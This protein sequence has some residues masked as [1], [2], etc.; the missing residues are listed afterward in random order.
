MLEGRRYC[1]ELVGSG[2]VWVAASFAAL[3]ALNVL[4]YLYGPGQALA[5]IG[6][7]RYGPLV[8]FAVFDSWGTVEGLLGTVALFVPLL[9]VAEGSE[10]RAMSAFFVA[11][12]LGAGFAAS[13]IWNSFLGGGRLGY[14]ASSIPF[15]AQSVLFGLSVFGLIRLSH[16][17]G[18][19][20]PGGT[21]R[22]FSTVVYLVLAGGALFLVLSLE[23][24][25]TPTA[26]YNWQTHELAFLLGLFATTVYYAWVSRK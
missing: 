11:A 15:A 16:K 17:R 5:E 10:R 6:T 23:P 13:L 24:I 7:S 14:G 21:S 4:T 22:A 12:S 25:F 1:R 26:L 2:F 19:R 18:G 8:S 9:A 3:A 20:P